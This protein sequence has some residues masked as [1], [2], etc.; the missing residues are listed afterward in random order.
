[1]KPVGNKDIFDIDFSIGSDV[2][3]QRKTSPQTG[4][5]VT[6]KDIVSPVGYKQPEIPRSPKHSKVQPKASSPRSSNLQGSVTP[7]LT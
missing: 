4:S 6:K 1:M 3:T 5:K 2:K 7:S